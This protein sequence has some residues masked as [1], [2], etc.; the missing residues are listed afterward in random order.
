MATAQS[1][2]RSARASNPASHA[3]YYPRYTGLNPHHYNTTYVIY[4]VK[5]WW[6]FDMFKTKAVS[7]NARGALSGLETVSTLYR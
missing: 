6:V 2:Q 4:Q 3:E 7:I 5:Q 1:L